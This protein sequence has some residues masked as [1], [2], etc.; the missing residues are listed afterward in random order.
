M[1]TTWAGIPGKQ[2][3]VCMC[4]EGAAC[5]ALWNKS[6]HHGVGAMESE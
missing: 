3:G 4:E 1:T 5:W 6:K 2:A